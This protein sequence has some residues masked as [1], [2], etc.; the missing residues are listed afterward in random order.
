MLSYTVHAPSGALLSSHLLDVT[1]RLPDVT[2]VLSPASATPPPLPR[3]VPMDPFETERRVFADAL[4]TLL[5]SHDGQY[6]V[7]HKTRLL[8]V[9]SS[10]E[11]AV[12]LGWTTTNS[13]AFFVRRIE[14]QV[15]PVVLPSRVA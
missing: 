14:R 7:V 4:P 9:R 8:G 12:E 1:S 13:R 15:G 5:N 10:L 3:V 11:S 2:S 6:A